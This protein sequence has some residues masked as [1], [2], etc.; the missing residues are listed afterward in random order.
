MRPFALTERG[1]GQPTVSVN[2]LLTGQR[3]DIDATGTLTI[4]DYADEIVRGGF[5]T[6][7]EVPDRFR[8]AAW[9]SYL[10]ELF[11]R[12]LPELGRPVRRGQMLQA[13]LRAYASATSTTASYTTILDAAMPADTDKPSQSTTIAW[14]ETLAR[15]WLVEPLPAWDDPLHRLPTLAKS[16]KHHLVDPALAAH[17]LGIT[18]A[19]LLEQ[20][21]PDQR[22]VPRRATLFGAL[23][24]SLVAQSVRVIAEIA[25]ATVSHLRTKNGDHEVDLIVTRPDGKAVAIEVKAA[26]GV[27]TGDLKHLHWLQDKLGTDLLDSVVITSGTTAY[28]RTSDGIVVVPAALIGL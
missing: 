14:R 24:E 6:L 23:F 27:E 15:L 5:P 28:R 16:P 17:L 1:L 19:T 12:D 22:P 11:E 3:P 9:N 21:H 2:A 7:R 13:W 26:P 8:R 18:A 25:D 10:A 4:E 20:P